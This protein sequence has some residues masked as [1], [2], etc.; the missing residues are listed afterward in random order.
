M[1]QRSGEPWQPKPWQSLILSASKEWKG[2]TLKMKILKLSLAATVYT[3]WRER[4]ARIFRNAAKN[5]AIILKG[6]I[7]VIRSILIT[8][9]VK[10]STKIM[11]FFKC[12]IFPLLAELLMDGSYLSCTFCELNL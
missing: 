1:L 5:S 4:N 10:E 8:L 2:K 12:G 3:L 9:K 6:I 7:N 11:P